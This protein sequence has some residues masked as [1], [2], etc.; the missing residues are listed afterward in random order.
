[1]YVQGIGAETSL[2]FRVRLPAFKPDKIRRYSDVSPGGG[3]GIW[4][5]MA[6]P[7][8]RK[9]AR[10]RDEADTS[11]ILTGDKQSGVENS[12]KC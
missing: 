6:R 2:A 12:E 10:S 5:G 7:K 4:A 3:L 8:T 11:S 9:K 1:M